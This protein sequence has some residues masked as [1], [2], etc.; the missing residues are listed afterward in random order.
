M[1]GTATKPTAGEERAIGTAGR[2]AAIGAVVAAIVVVAM[3][4]FGGGGGYHVKAYFENAGQLVSGNQVEIG[5]T[6]AGSVDGFSLTDNGQAEVKMTVADKYRPLPLGTQA[7][8]RQASQSGIANR[9]V[10]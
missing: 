6:P 3:L 1:G 10:E 5:G 9:Y 8:I 2:V 7:V 4:L